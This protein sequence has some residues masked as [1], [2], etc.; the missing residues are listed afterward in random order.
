MGKHIKY[1]LAIFLS[2]FDLLAIA[3]GGVLLAWSVFTGQPWYYSVGG[4][5]LIVLGLAFW[6]PCRNYRV[7]TRRDVE[8][9]EFGLSKSKG[10]YEYLSKA[11]RDQIDLKKTADME[12]LLSAT[13]LKKMT[14]QGSVNPMKDLHDMI[15][16]LPV[17]E[18][19]E[20]MVARMEFEQEE[21]KQHKSKKKNQNSMGSMG[22][23][24]MCF[25]GAPGTGKTQLHASLQ[26]FYISL[27]I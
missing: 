7:K 8:Y 17:K 24:H 3:A 14:K 9:D 16:L 13:A 1:N 20:E 11:E 6:Y 19:V 22:G 25:T 5:I 15:G 2:I 10:N 21:K 23:R 4:A 18:K 26:V 27:G 12:R